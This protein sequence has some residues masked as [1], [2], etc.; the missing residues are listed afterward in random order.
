VVEINS[1]GFWI[2]KA[3][4]VFEKNGTQIFDRTLIT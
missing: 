4:A 2:R 1:G 3:D